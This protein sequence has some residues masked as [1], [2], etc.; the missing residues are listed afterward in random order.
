VKGSEEKQSKRGN[1][2]TAFPVL[3]KNKNTHVLFAG[4]KF[5]GV[6]GNFCTTFAMLLSVGC[7]RDFMVQRPA[8][9]CCTFYQF[10][11]SKI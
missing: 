7:L 6:S 11:W 10:T 2:T 9:N 1:S 8:D 5:P 4:L 3:L